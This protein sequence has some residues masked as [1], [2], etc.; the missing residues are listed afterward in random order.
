MCVGG[1]DRRV[2]NLDISI[3]TASSPPSEEVEVRYLL[4]GQSTRGFSLLSLSINLFIHFLRPLYVGFVACHVW[5]K[6]SR[7]VAA[8]LQSVCS[9]LI[10]MQL[11][12]WCTVVG[13]LCNRRFLRSD[14]WAARGDEWN[15]LKIQRWLNSA[16]GTR[17]WTQPGMCS[18]GDGALVTGSDLLWVLQDGWQKG[19]KVLDE[20]ASHF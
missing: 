3:S 9:W 12:I 17:E 15:A 2:E 8:G 19:D 14:V 7:P 5:R 4:G 11:C 6:A 13:S 18:L 10:H 16:C 1:G 20:V